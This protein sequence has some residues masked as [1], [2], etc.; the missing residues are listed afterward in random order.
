MI[1]F[2]REAVIS[3]GYQVDELKGLWSP[4][5]IQ[6]LEDLPPTTQRFYIQYAHVSSFLDLEN[7][8]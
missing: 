2:K 4:E 7:F 1:P 5:N 8:N 6:F 3:A